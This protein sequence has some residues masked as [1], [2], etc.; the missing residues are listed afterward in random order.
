MEDSQA[1]AR[2]AAFERQPGEALKH[3]SRFRGRPCPCPFSL[4]T[5]GSRASG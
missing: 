3:L 5:G 4:Q 2:V 1:G